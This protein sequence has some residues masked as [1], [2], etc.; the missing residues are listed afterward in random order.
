[1]PILLKIFL[2]I[3]FLKFI[4][5]AYR[6]LRI[7][8]LSKQ[9]INWLFEDRRENVVEKKEE[10]ISLWK[11]AGIGDAV[12]PRLDD[13]GYGKLI[14]YKQH[15]FFSFPSNY[16]DMA[17]ATKKAFLEAKGVYKKR[18]KDAINPIE[19]IILFV[20]LP[21]RI[22]ASIGITKQKGLINILQGI[23]WIIGI[24]FTVVLSLYPEN[25]RVLLESF[26]FKH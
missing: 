19:W 5:N 21:Q 1:M 15:L 3:V 8:M 4:I 9:Y 12:I 23:Y 2:V 18:I 14:T 25:I 20:Y 17:M 10:V 22:L 24:A 7:K 13:A 6:L 11:Q 16:E 26:I